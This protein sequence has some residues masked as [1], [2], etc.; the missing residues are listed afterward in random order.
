MTR[1][2]PALWTAGVAVAAL[3]GGGVGLRLLLTGDWSSLAAWISAALFIPSLAL[4]LGIWSGSRI[5]FEALYTVWWYIGPAHHLRGIDFLGTTTASS[6]PEFYALAA[7]VLL[8]MSYWKRRLR[9]G[10]A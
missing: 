10:Y 3:T 2:L 4:V 6:R 1:Q 5:P 7:G 9:I 8:A